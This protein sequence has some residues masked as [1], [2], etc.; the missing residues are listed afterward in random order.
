M[1][2]MLLQASPFSRPISY[3]LEWAKFDCFGRYAKKMFLFLLGPS[4]SCWQAHLTSM[5]SGARKLTW[6]HLNSK[7]IISKG[8][9]LSLALTKRECPCSAAP[10][11]PGDKVCH[12]WPAIMQSLRCDK[13][14]NDKG[15]KTYALDLRRTTGGDETP[16]ASVYSRPTMTLHVHD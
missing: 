11:G 12:P 9:K 3:C 2:R 8:M 10:D 13:L 5:T 15:T 6:W 14:D 4:E 1:T 7:T 16:V